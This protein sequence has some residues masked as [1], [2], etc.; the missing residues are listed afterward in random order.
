M[1][2]LRK[3]ARYLDGMRPCKQT[4]AVIEENAEATR[5]LSGSISRL[6][7]TLTDYRPQKRRATDR[8]DDE[9]WRQRSSVLR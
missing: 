3:A 7:E 2:A 1:Q 4:L 5:E 9:S 8:E 6:T